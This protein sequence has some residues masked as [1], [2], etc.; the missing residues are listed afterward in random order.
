MAVLFAPSEGVK[1]DSCIVNDYIRFGLLFPGE[2]LTSLVPPAL[3]G[4]NGM[5]SLI[6]MANYPSHRLCRNLGKL[7]W[8]KKFVKQQ[9]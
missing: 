1:H 6:T 4:N 8:K 9:V 7:Q 5:M 2:A 3:N